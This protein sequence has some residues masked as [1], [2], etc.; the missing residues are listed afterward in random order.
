M[1]RAEADITK[2]LEYFIEGM[3][4]S[5][6]NVLQRMLIADTN[7]LP[8]QSAL[9]RKLDP[10]QR[11]ILAL[12]EEYEVVTSSQ[13]GKFFGFQPRT[14]YKI[15]S[16]WVKSGF[17]EIVDSSNRGRKYRLANSNRILS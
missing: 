3:A 15:C 6:E 9:L 1:G 17:L 8:D 16:D 11:K 10:R 7:G 4:I 14:S 12:F 5:F 2:W 13:I